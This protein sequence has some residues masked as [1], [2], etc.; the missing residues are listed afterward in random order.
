MVHIYLP[1]QELHVHNYY[2]A[3]KWERRIPAFQNS[4]LKAMEKVGIIVGEFNYLGTT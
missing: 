4:I 1:Q 3:F 2:I